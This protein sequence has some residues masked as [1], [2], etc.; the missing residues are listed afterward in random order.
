MP[1]CILILSRFTLRVDN[2]LFCAHDTRIYHSFAST[3]PIVVTYA[4]CAAGKRRT[5]ASSVYEFSF[6]LHPQLISALSRPC[7][8]Q[9][10][11][12]SAKHFRTCRR[13]RRRRL[14]PVMASTALELS[15]RSLRCSR[16]RGDEGQIWSLLYAY[17][18][19]GEVYL[20]SGKCR[21]CTYCELGQ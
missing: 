10:R 19:F 6:L 16:D 4:R 18:A 13:R 12:S 5:I 17:F 14:A 8:S 21:F 9:T 20:T 1:T 3:P 2:V 7:R 11:T 15:Y